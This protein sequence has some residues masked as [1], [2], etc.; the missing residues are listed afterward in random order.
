MSKIRQR[1]KH[2][3]YSGL[4][5]AA[6]MGVLF[7]GYAVYSHK[8]NTDQQTS[9]REDYELQIH[10]MEAAYLKEQ[11][12]MKSGFAVKTS[13]QPGQLLQSADLI[14]VKLPADAAPD[15]LLKEKKQIVGRT[16]KIALLSGTPITE[17]MIH[18]GEPTTAD[19]RHKEVSTIV[20][21]TDLKAEDVVDIRITFPNGLD[22]IVLSK[23]KVEKLLSP[24]MW[25]TLDEQEILTLSSAVVDAY[26]HQASIYAITYV[27]PQMQDKAI[28]NYPVNVDV[29]KLIKSDPNII[30]VAERYLSETVRTQLEKQ[31]EKFRII[32]QEVGSYP[33][34]APMYHIP[35]QVD[36]TGSGSYPAAKTANTPDESSS[37][38]SFD[39]SSESATS[40][41][42]DSE[43]NEADEAAAAQP[44]ESAPVVNSNGQGPSFTDIQD[45]TSSAGYGQ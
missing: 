20:L 30:K 37:Y 1:T 31:L 19:L 16:A 10:E 25:I 34:S 26:I 28:P 5:G 7:A 12:A 29:Q 44:V 9:I 23:K 32:E 33:S 11:Q 39:H 43:E 36:G 45:D 17:A 2:L 22:Y 13:L 38:P 4:V 41:L 42:D 27:E 40:Q 6:V 15:N 24:T 21:P 14:E 3:I 35:S 18:E 8:V